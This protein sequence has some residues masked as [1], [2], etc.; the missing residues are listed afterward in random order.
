MTSRNKGKRRYQG[1]GGEKQGCKIFRVVHKKA[2]ERGN[3]RTCTM[4][5]FLHATHAVKRRGGGERHR[6]LGDNKTHRREQ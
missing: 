3:T 5:G 1:G 6:A 2:E 4:T